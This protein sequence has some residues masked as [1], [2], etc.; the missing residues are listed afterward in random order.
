[1]TTT[2]IPLS[3]IPYENATITAAVQEVKNGMVV[4]SNRQVATS[5][6]ELTIN[7]PNGRLI[8]SGET[9]LGDLIADAFRITMNAD[10][11]LINGGGVRSGI[12]AGVITYGDIVNVLPH[13]NNVLA[14]YM[15]KTLGGT[16]GTTYAQPA[17]RITIVN[18]N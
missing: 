7:G 15:E 2:L 11:G 3:E 6:Y 13:D 10:I 16:T 18:D 4:L 14:Y 12:P 1:M 5:D 17:Q 9:N 8:R